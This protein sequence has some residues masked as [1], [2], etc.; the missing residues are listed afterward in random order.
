MANAERGEVSL[1]L[2]GKVYTLALSLNA[3]VALEELFS[4]PEKLM[5]FEEVSALADKG[6]IKHVRALIWSVFQDYHPEVTL[7]GVSK[8]V[9]AAGGLGVL[10]VK[11]AEL[12]KASTPDPKDLKKLGVKAN[13]PGARAARSGTGEGS[14]SRPV[15][16]A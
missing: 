16:Q 3:M 8:L 7:T 11:L 14:T 9:T 15:A 1:T 2:D 13:P 12:A 6:S 5:T 10:T 4:T